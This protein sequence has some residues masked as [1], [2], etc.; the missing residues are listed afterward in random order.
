[1]LVSVDSFLVHVAF[2]VFGLMSHV[3]CVQ[4]HFGYYVIELWILFQSP[5]LVSVHGNLSSRAK[6]DI[7]SLPLGGEVNPDSLFP[8][9]RFDNEHLEWYSR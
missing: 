2:L 5:I 8:V 4:G 6:R 1:M 3:Q 7:D 9:V